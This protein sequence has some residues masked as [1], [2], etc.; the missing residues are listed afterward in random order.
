MALR[1]TIDVFSG[2]KNP[3][4]ELKGS[5]A[6]DALKRLQPAKR[7][8]RGEL[9]MPPTPTL[10]YRGLIVE[11]TGRP[12]KTLPKLFR[13]AHGDAFGLGLS[14]HIED[15]AFEDFICGSTGPIR[16]LR[17]GKPF[18]LR[19]KREINRF[20]KVRTKWPLRK[21]P[22]WPL[23]CRCRCAPLYEPGW[24]NDAGQIQYNNNCYNYGCNYRSD[25]YA[26]PGEAAGAK[27]AS[28]SCAEVKAGAIADELINK[29]LA[30]NRCPREGH[31]VAL[32]VGPG[33]DFHWYRKGRNH[34][35]THKPGWGEATNLD[36][37]GKLIRDPRTADRGGYTSFC[38][39]MVVM[40]GHIKIT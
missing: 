17:L 30:N 37:S 26:Q 4:I 21:K 3:V 29:P 35:W 19:L 15:A 33:W 38:T 7:I 8:K 28:I 40:H 34:L 25:T 5:D 36:N 12:S 9:G 11:Q 14:H 10:G 13:V 27:Y 20:H 18:H 2:R 22:R 23:R 31:L 1:I 39:F 24:W 6:T 32:V 16:K